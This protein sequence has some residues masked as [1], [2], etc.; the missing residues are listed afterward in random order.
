VDEALCF[1]WIDGIRRSHGDDA[2]TIRFTPRRSTS[3]WSAVN[4]ARVGELTRLKR[5]QP[6]GLAAFARRKEDKS[7]IYSY[8]QKHE[9]V[10]DGAL[11]NRF[12]AN[13]KAWAF[14]QAQPPYYRRTLT[15]FVASAKGAA[16]RLRRLDKL[17]AACESGR[18]LR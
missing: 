17:M 13:R 9:A 5:M 4:L 14:F 10:L 16:T 2:Y 15:R 8:E 1:G 6:A 7:R 11:E 12:R 18:R 3:I